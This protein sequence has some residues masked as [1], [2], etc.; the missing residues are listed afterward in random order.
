MSTQL[1]IA[2]I[3][4]VI[5]LVSAGVAVTGQFRVARYQA[6]IE[7]NR[8]ISEKEDEARRIVARFREPLCQAAFDLQ[9]RLYN[10]MSL[11]IL[12][13]F[14]VNGSKREQDYVVE[15]TLYVFGEYLGW[16]EIIRGEVR[17]LDLNDVE[18]G[19]RLTEL[20]RQISESLLRSDLPPPFRLFKGEQRAIGELMLESGQQ[21]CLGPATFAQQSDAPVRQWFETL[22]A[23]IRWLAAQE[24]RHLERL[25]EVQHGLVDL[26][27]FLDPDGHRF[28]DFDCEK[29][30]APPATPAQENGA[31]PAS[32]GRL[33]GRV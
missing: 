5:S 7:A 10:M 25:V 2:I 16:T 12:D 23:D 17:F 27:H 21:H 26:I 28:P 6:S 14:F 1:T 20:Q 4:A 15:N 33:G 13:R 3:A 9:S 8:E 11:D 24:D 29:V 32:T 22:E 19:R 18:Q 31:A 30:V